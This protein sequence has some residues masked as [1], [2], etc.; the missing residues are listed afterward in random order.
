MPQA[1]R[2]G[3]GLVIAYWPSRNTATVRRSRGAWLQ[4]RSAFS[5]SLSDARLIP[6]RG[7]RLSMAPPAGSFHDPSSTNDNTM[8]TSC[9][10]S[11]GKLPVDD[12]GVV[13][14]LVAGPA[15]AV[16]VGILGGPDLADQRG[17]TVF[18]DDVDHGGPAKLV[19][20]VVD[21]GGSVAEQGD[22]PQPFQRQ[23][24]GG[25]RAGRRGI[26]GGGPVP[27]G[28]HLWRPA[29]TEV[30]GDAGVGQRQVADAL[31][32]GADRG[33]RG[34]RGG[35][36]RQVAAS[37]VPV[38]HLPDRGRQRAGQRG[39]GLGGNRGQQVGAEGA[40]VPGHAVHASGVRAI[41]G[42]GAAVQEHGGPGPNARVVLVR[43]PGRSRVG[44]HLDQH[45][46]VPSPAGQGPVTSL[47]SS[48]PGHGG[49]VTATAESG[50]S[51]RARNWNRVPTGIDRQVPGSRGMVSSRPAWLRHISPRPLST[52]QISS[53]LRCA[54][55]REVRPPASS[56]CAI[57]PPASRS[58]IRT[59][60]PSGATTSRAA[61]SRMVSNG[62][63][64]PINVAS[65][66]RSGGNEK[67]FPPPCR[68]WRGPLV[69]KVE[70]PARC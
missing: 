44:G 58:R 66:R 50:P 14:G 48:S 39:P 1:T 59:S 53:T 64:T 2:T 9:R 32:L 26:R 11:P 45:G 65:H 57:E 62:W 54:T 12:R 29:V 13:P 42:G 38:P 55:A 67:F 31:G 28:D 47:A 22:A 49:M 60:E 19:V 23:G 15:L 56:K 37:G 33:D 25:S 17:G 40:G 70:G 8:S 10:H 3:A 41:R 7:D 30:G 43:P 24:A 36:Q 18:P 63:S 61:G 51:P 6:V 35:P 27:V 46:A 5:A 68:S 20:Q 16:R 52:Y 4:A 69:W 21:A 34:G